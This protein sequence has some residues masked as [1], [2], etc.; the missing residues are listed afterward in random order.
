MLGL[1]VKKRAA[2]IFLLM[3]L[4]LG[5]LVLRLTFIQVIRAPALQKQALGQRLRQIPVD[6]HRGAIR[7]RNGAILAGSTDG[8]CIGAVPIEVKDPV[9]T[10]SVLAP[11]LHLDRA[12]LAKKLELHQAFVWIK[13][14]LS[15]DAARAVREKR[16]PGILVLLKA[17]RFYPTELAG[18]LLGFA[19]S[20][21]Q[22]L[23]GLE[24]Y[25]DADLRGQKGWNMAEFTSNG[26]HIPGGER[27]FQAPVNGNTL[28]L[29]IDRG[30]Q[31]IAERELDRAIAETGAK[32]GMVLIMDPRNGEILAMVNRPRMDPGHFWE[33]PQSTWRNMCV[34][35]QYEPGSTFK[36]ITTA[37]ALEEGVVSLDSKFFD[38]GYILVDG[39]Y[40]NCW[41]DG[42]HGSQTFTEALQN[43][44]NPVFASLAMTLGP[45]RFLKYA[46]AF[47][48]GSRI[49]IDFPGEASGIVPKLSGLKR[50]ELATMGFGQGI[51]ITPMQLMGAAAAI[52]NG[53]FLVRP[54]FLKEICDQQNRVIRSGKTEIIRQVISRK[55]SAI[56]RQLLESVVVNGSGNKAGVAGYR[57]A[58]KTGTAQKPGDGGYGSQVMTSFIG[59]TPVDNPR[60]VCLVI[61]DEPQK[62]IRYGG[63]IAAPVFSRIVGSILRNL[64]IQPTETV[65]APTGDT[66]M[67]TVP[68]LLNEQE[69]SA[70]KKLRQLGLAGKLVGWGEYVLDQMP[71]PGARVRVGTT[72][73]LY[74]DR[75][76][77]YNNLVEDQVK[78]PDLSGVSSEA[79]EKILNSLGLRLVSIGDGVVDTQEPAPGGMVR[80]G[81]IV[82]VHL[83]PPKSAPIKRG[84]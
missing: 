50:I 67:V 33:Y 78:V 4:C 54:H 11:L 69:N 30:M 70:Q 46:K 26:M 23:E 73:L 27:R 44:C 66:S 15:S 71:K 34:T 56:M 1:R 65:P 68:N 35:D 38:P 79:A 21:N 63:V 80:P 41:Y 25:Y 29:T 18:Q 47:G 77:K 37:A 59:F 16:L 58:G 53:G 57:I 75:A 76:E 3:A 13:L 39:H 49:G 28:Y 9:Y 8:D 7:D 42:G 43:S 10:A 5:L 40:I 64:N 60:L 81:S 84:G 52:A 55:T 83:I 72:V 31:F 2:V 61:L 20:E 82:T 32:K 74:I 24:V 36:I 19:G 14:R 22:G 62:G 48:L 17:Q 6:A 45:D 12:D 51:S